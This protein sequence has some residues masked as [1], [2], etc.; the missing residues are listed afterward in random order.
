MG[1]YSSRLLCQKHGGELRLQNR[2]A[3]GAAAAA[4]FRI[5]PGP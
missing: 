4:S 2:P 5:S 1:L 3:G